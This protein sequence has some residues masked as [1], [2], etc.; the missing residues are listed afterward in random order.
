MTSPFTQK[1][2]AR[3]G[4]G[5]RWPSVSRGPCLLS[6][7]RTPV[8]ADLPCCGPGGWECLCY[9]LLDTLLTQVKNS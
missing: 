6:A 2:E 4:A 5:G 7:N 8:A 1:P 3:A 9:M